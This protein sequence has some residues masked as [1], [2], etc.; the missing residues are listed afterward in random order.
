M[1][2][3]CGVILERLLCVYCVYSCEKTGKK[4]SFWV[5]LE[6]PRGPFWTQ[7][8]LSPEYLDFPSSL[9]AGPALFRLWFSLQV[10]AGPPLTN[11]WRLPSLLARHAPITEYVPFTEYLLITLS[12]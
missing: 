8:L 12:H 11:L 1:L 7:V 2:S 9:V 4:S 3:P 5:G 6:P 10:S